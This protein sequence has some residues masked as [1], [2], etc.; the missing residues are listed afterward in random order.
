MAGPSLKAPFPWFGGKRLAAELVWARFGNV[1]NYV[2]PFAGSLAVLLARPHAPRVETVNDLD[3]Y[4]SNFWRATQH[5]PEAVARYAD[6]PVNEADLRARHQWL[7]LSAASAEFRDRMRADPDYYDAKIAGWWCWGLCCWIGAGWCSGNPAAAAPTHASRPRLSHATS[8]LGVIAG[9][10]ATQK[11]PDLTGHAG[12]TGRGILA[13]GGPRKKRSQQLP[14]LSGASGASGRGIHASAGPTKKRPQ[15]SGDGFSAGISA[16]C[17]EAVRLEW[18]LG[19][20]ARLRDRLRQVRVCCGDW[21]RVCGSESVTT[22]IGL[23]GI[24]LDPPYSSATGRDP[25]LYAEDCGQVAHAVRTYCLERGNDPRLRIALC[26]YA[27]EHE[28]LEEH[29]WSVARWRA[30]GGYG[31]RSAKGLANRGKERIWF[32]PHCLSQRTLF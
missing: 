6:W 14:D 5:D 7:V 23:T 11:L 9:C 1:A 16:S 10:Q 17:P 29:G 28:E 31:N 27:G 12:A 19:W 20:F 25:D 32:S 3:C 26:G 24:F 2:E 21:T 13:S 4:L 22:R 15:Q 18:I 8:S 30:N